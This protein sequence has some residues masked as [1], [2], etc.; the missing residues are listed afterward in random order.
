MCLASSHTYGIFA[1]L[2][3]AETQ[4]QG[5]ARRFFFGDFGRK[6]ARLSRLN[7]GKAQQV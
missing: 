2:P 6:A 1:A 4:A 3:Q 7:S 5:F